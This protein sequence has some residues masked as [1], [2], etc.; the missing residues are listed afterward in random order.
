MQDDF[1]MHRE[2]SRGWIRP[3]SST[4]VK[5]QSSNTVQ[6][7][8]QELTDGGRRF[9]KEFIHTEVGIYMLQGGGGFRACSPG[10]FW[11]LRSQMTHSKPNFGWN[12][13]VFLFFEPWTRGGGADCAPL[14]IR[15]WDLRLPSAQRRC[16]SGFVRLRSLDLC[17][18]CG[19][20]L[21]TSQHHLAVTADMAVTGDT[22]YRKHQKVT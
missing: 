21:E 16:T 13:V 1:L 12:M 4:R 6:W 10:K 19:I 18:Q 17:D 3:P 2:D 15:H 20:Y 14:W 11:N 9:L 8:I 5:S 22:K 7:Q